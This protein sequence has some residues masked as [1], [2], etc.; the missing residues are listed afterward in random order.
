MQF[1]DVNEHFRDEI[2]RFGRCCNEAGR[3]WPDA[4]GKRMVFNVAVPVCREGQ[5]LFAEGMLFDRQIQRLVS[6]GI[7]EEG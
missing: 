2:T 4:K 3:D 6:D 5:K 1:K 7:L